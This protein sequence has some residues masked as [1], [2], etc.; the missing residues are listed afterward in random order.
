VVGEM[1]RNKVE[2]LLGVHHGSIHKK[3]PCIRLAGRP[4]RE[5]SEGRKKG[6]ETRR[7][8]LKKE[9]DKGWETPLLAAAKPVR[10]GKLKDLER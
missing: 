8:C 6:F 7:G 2:P 1:G 10:G 4:A 9:G 5:S 3:K